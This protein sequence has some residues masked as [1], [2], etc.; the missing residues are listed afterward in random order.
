MFSEDVMTDPQPERIDITDE[1]YA[2]R[3]NRHYKVFFPYD[4]D[5]VM[6]AG[7]LPKAM[8]NPRGRCWEVSDA[9]P[10]R[11]RQ[12]M[13]EIA[14]ITYANRMMEDPLP[15]PSDDDGFSP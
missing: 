11:L 4:R 7:G 15:A 2:I 14:K 13:E 8:F 3:S 1:V 12:G 9:Y 10:E 5:A 6:I